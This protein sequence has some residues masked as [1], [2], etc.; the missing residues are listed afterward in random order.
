MSS[1]HDL[2]TPSIPPRVSSKAPA[3]FLPPHSLCLFLRERFF[4]WFGALRIW[5]I[6]GREKT[7]LFPRRPSILLGK[8]IF[9][10]PNIWSH[11]DPASARFPPSPSPFS[12]TWS[13][14][15][16]HAFLSDKAKKKLV[17]ARRR[18]SFVP[19]VSE[20]FSLLFTWSNCHRGDRYR[21]SSL[22]F[23]ALTGSP[24]F[25][26]ERFNEGAVY[27]PLLNLSAA[28]RKMISLQRAQ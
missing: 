20:D 14:G 6:R 15:R 8:T 5:G 26:R 21:A 3:Q 24:I 17:M 1:S 12:I 13:R 10:R 9:S 16:S 23:H 28:E 22:P 4:R 19:T 11:T 2:S 25:E 27:S 7:K 18:S